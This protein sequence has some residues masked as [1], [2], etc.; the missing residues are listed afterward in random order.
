[1]RYR[2]TL[3][4]TTTPRLIHHQLAM[5]DLEARIDWRTLTDWHDRLSNILL[6]TRRSR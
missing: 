1:M 5:F 4:L 6:G 2:I 3:T